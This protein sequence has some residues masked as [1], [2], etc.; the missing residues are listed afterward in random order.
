MEMQDDEIDDLFRSKLDGFEMEPSINVWRGVTAGLQPRK[1]K[2][3]LMPF[4][5]IAA[6]IL[7]LITAGILFTPQRRGVAVKHSALTKVTKT[8]S[9]HTIVA[10]AN[11]TPANYA[12]DLTLAENK[13]SKPINKIASNNKAETVKVT[14]G[15]NVVVNGKREIP[16]QPV[17]QPVIASVITKPD[18]KDVV[19]PG[20]ETKLLPKQ[21]VDE[22]RTSFTT[23]PVLIAD[24]LPVQNSTEVVPDLK[25]KH[26]IHNLGDL[27]NVVVAKVDKRKDKVIV[28]AN[29]DGE[30]EA[31][32]TGVNLG[33]IKFRKEK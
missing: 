24:Q 14:P 25:P 27:L 5:S 3:L 22:A 13:P 29:R 10:Q 9:S 4:L 32:V 15:E 30:E 8:H 12:P 11:N 2:G 6:S 7:V 20:N 26:K 1:G 21:P 33:I 19:L 28:F 18:G 16:A 23:K 17:E 31:T